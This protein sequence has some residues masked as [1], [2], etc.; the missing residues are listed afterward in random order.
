MPFSEE[1]QKFFNKRYYLFSKFDGGIKLDEESWY[2]V[3]PEEISKHIA[4]RVSDVFGDN[5]AIVMDAFCGCGGNTI[6]FGKKS[7]KVIAIDIDETKA[8][9]A[10]YNS[11][12]YY[13]QD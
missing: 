5:K 9:Y 6:Q 2:S 12:I 8:D 13:V 11:A 7:K 1:G 4:R 3:T 10:K